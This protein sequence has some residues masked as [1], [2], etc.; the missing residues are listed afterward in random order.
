[1]PLSYSPSSGFIDTLRFGSYLVEARLTLF[2]NGEQSNFIVPISTA[3]VTV[4]RNAARRRQG[5]F[6]AELTPLGAQAPNPM[7]VLV[8][9]SPSSPLTPFGDELLLEYSVYVPGQTPQW[10]NMG[11]YAITG[12]TVD[13]TTSDM[14]VTVDIADR[15]FVIAQRAFIMPYV[16]PK[17]GGNFVQEITHLI[18]FVWGTNQ[19]TGLPIPHMPPLVYNITPTNAQVPLATYDQGSDPWQAALDMANA[20][21]YELFF[22]LNGEVRGYPIPDPLTQAVTWNFSDELEALQSAPS[23]P[24]FGSPFST[25]IAVQVSYTRDGIYNDIYVTGTGTSNA[26]YSNTGNYEPIIAE[27]IDQ[28]PGSATNIYSPLGD[29]PEFVASNL[30][31]SSGQARSIARNDLVN[32]VSSAWQV[33]ITASPNPLF[34]VDDVVT[35][36]R[37]R[38]GLNNALVIVDQI[39]HVVSYADSLTLTGR[40]VSASATSRASVI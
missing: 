8:P 31:T 39:Q 37:P 36:T 4:D 21:G 38:V 33:M 19:G 40:V 9:S 34:D 16:F 6:T 32:S 5:T 14:V 10:V 22:G 26:P 13:D 15:S 24:L 1:M 30:A 25:P 20:C 3:T 12:V 29:L 35:V 27:A 2:H 17:V 7:Q 28:N 18:N 11:L 23:R